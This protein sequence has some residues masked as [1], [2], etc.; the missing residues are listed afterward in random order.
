MLLNILRKAFGTR[1]KA[2]SLADR[3]RQLQ[4]SI[5]HAV[6]L[7]STGDTDAAIDA[8]EAILKRE[9]E[10]LPALHGMALLLVQK[11]QNQ[12][13]LAIAE[14]LTERLPNLPE[15][16]MVRA[17]AAR[18]LNLLED[19]LD[20][21]NRSVALRPD[22]AMVSCVGVLEFH[23]G[24]IADAIKTFERASAL[25]PHDDSIHS[26]RLFALTCLSGYSREQLVKAHFDWGRDVESRIAPFS[27]E[28]ANDPS[29]GRRL[30]IGYVSADLRIHP[31][32]AL[33][34]PILA[35][36]NRDLVEIFCYDN[37]GGPG[38]SVTRRLQSKADH[39][40]KCHQASDAALAQR[41]QEDKIDILVDLSG[42][43]AGNR[44][45]VFAMR[46][47]P[48][49]ISWF[50]YMCTT[51]LT[52]IDYRLSDATLCPKD[53]EWAYSERVFRLPTAVAWAPSPDSPEPGNLPATDNGFIT[54]GSFNNWSKVTDVAIEC[55]AKILHRCVNSRL[56]L[57]ATG[58]DTPGVQSGIAKLFGKHGI[59]EERLDISGTTSLA[60]FLKVVREADIA[61]DPFPY[62]GGT[63]SFHCLWMGVP[64]VTLSSGDELGRA[65]FGILN[66]VG[67]PELCAF[68]EADY[69]DVAV[70]LAHDTGKL[71]RLRSNLRSTLASTIIMDSTGV[72]SNVE[73][74]YRDM[75]LNWIE[76]RW[77][78]L[79]VPV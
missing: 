49:Q 47:A 12:R 19:A 4:E 70:T 15:S 66:V 26:N 11:G 2:L 16:W 55:W 67:S 36:H 48:V 32:A 37:H 65:G 34:E 73:A 51:G 53:S 17:L 41:I 21:A 25:S 9:P 39:W 22:P 79:G 60:N 20:A 43:T 33:L 18:G 5:A 7:A 57:I 35:H 76:K 38:D 74:A 30:K 13:A 52:R 50:G 23:L 59:G 27:R 61:L 3:E 56:R 42:H 64:I 54:F 71:Q 58:G 1:H 62:N 6:K 29:P 14:E 24:R 69:V 8:Y 72:T 44:L 10:A 68:S 31:V 78:R 28:F 45:P 46:P 40:M 63:T 77:I 75:W